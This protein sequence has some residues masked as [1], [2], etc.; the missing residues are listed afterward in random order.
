MGKGPS[1]GTTE[2]QVFPS[3]T[4]RVSPRAKRVILKISSRHGLEV[5][6]P[7]GFSQRN[8][9]KILSEKKAWI[10]Q[11]FRQMES[12][13]Q[14]LARSC[15]LPVAI[16]FQSVNKGFQVEYVPLPNGRLSLSHRT[17]SNLIFTGDYSDTGGC[18]ALLKRWLTHQARLH[19]IPWLNQ[20]SDQTGLTFRQA[21]I[22][23]Q[24][25]RWGS[26]STSGNISLNYNL[27]FLRPELVQ[28]IMHHELCHTIHMNH[29][30]NFYQL[31]FKW[32]KRYLENRSAM[33][34]V[35]ELVPW[36]AL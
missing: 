8:I 7:K 31:L 20:L 9:P 13:G 34:T 16:H 10:E 19:L 22:R 28:Y 27:L 17:G 6:I 33:K 30:K 14:V 35:W 36:W 24:K 12:K 15:D 32:E 18:Q 21:Q 26:C 11:G 2:G 25:S 3:Y 1:L 29:S 5:V 23:G 4:I